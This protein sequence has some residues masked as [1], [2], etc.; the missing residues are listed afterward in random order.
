MPELVA[1][2]CMFKGHKCGGKEGRIVF[3]WSTNEMD[4]KV[5]SLLVKDTEEM[6]IWRV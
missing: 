4:E 5:S 1:S 2:Q 6:V 3:G